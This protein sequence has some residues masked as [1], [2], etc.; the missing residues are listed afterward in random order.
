MARYSSTTVFLSL[1]VSIEVGILYSPSNPANDIRQALSDN[2]IATPEFWT[3]IFLCFALFTSVAALI[4]N[5]TAASV[6]SALSKENA[7]VV[8]RSSIGLYAAQL[9]SRLV[10]F[11]KQLFLVVV[12]LSFWI[13]MPHLGAIII[14][15]FAIILV[16]HIINTFSSMAKIIMLTGGMYHMNMMKEE[17]E[18][19][20]TPVQLADV[21]LKRAQIARQCDC[22]IMGQYKVD[23]QEMLTDIEE[24]RCTYPVT[25]D[26]INL[27]AT[28]LV[29]RRTS[30]MAGLAEFHDSHPHLR[31]NLG[32]HTHLSSAE[33]ELEDDTASN[34]LRSSLQ[35]SGLENHEHHEHNP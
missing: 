24:G 1:L 34:P 12:I 28:R 26:E 33:F 5:F 10:F 16:M 23:Y 17:Q 6:F 14:T 8:L 11:A 29:R 32:A 19:N 31:R 9:P 20:L 27:R 15:V 25:A 7:P 22:P 35:S 21:L 30:M 18:E 13:I 2:A 4:A 3:G